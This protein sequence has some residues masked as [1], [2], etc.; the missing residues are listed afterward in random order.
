[1]K[2]T[3]FIL[4]LAAVVLVSQVQPAAAINKEWSA[5]LGFVG[6]YLV[7][8]ACDSRTVVHEQV[9][10][11]SPPCSQVVVVE[12]PMI[13]TGH[14]EMQPQQIWVP[15][16]WTRVCGPCGYRSVWT[17]GYYRVEYIQVWV[18]D[19]PW[20]H[21]GRHHDRGHGGGHRR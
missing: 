17:P 16:C 9:V 13:V 19:G 8:N 15:G 11:A 6:G 21:D 20:R 1:M 3:L 5:V 18:S 12:E 4:A 14:Y 7:A 10:V 2:K